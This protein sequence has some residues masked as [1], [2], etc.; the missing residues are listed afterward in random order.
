MSSDNYT[1]S[2]SD[3]EQART[4]GDDSDSYQTVP[5][6]FESDIELDDATVPD[7]P[8][9]VDVDGHGEAA[10]RLVKQRKLDELRDEASEEDTVENF[11]A[12]AVVD[13]LKHHYVSPSF[14]DLTVKKYRDSPAGYYDPFFDAICPAMTAGEGN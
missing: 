1:P 7:D 4:D 3:D 11:G 13:I 9:V 2:D 10:A 12:K 6:G 5:A 8:V 14:E